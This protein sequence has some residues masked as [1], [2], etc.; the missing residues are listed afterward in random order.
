MLRL[1]QFVLMVSV[2][3]SVCTSCTSSKQ[4]ACTY[5]QNNRSYEK[6]VK[7]PYKTKTFKKRQHSSYKLIYY[8]NYLFANQN[9]YRAINSAINKHR[10]DFTY[11]NPEKTDPISQRK[12]RKR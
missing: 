1:S 6:N 9:N 12:R 4:M 5:F 11:N 8:K 10:I 2:Y 7:K 3:G